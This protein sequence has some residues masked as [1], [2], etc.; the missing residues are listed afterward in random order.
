MPI[1]EQMINHL[2]FDRAQELHDKPRTIVPFTNIPESDALLNNI[3]TY[4]HFFILGCIMDRQI[5][6]E[7]AWNIPYIISK[8]CGGE[9]FENFLSLNS[10]VLNSIFFKKRLH[11]FN[12]QMASYFHKAVQIIHTE[13][14]DNAANIWLVGQPSCKEVIKRFDKFPGIGQKISTMATNILVRDFKVPIRD[15]HEID[16]SVDAQIKKVFKR[17]GIVPANASNQIIIEVARKIYPKYPGIADSVIWEIGRDWC[18]IDLSE[19]HKCF[20]NDY[21]PKNPVSIDQ[22]KNPGNI[23]SRKTNTNEVVNNKSGTLVIKSEKYRSRF[24]EL[25]R[26]YQKNIPQNFKINFTSSKTNAVIKAHD[27]PDGVHYEFDDWKDKSISIEIQLNRSLAPQILPALIEFSKR[28]ILDL[29]S[30]KIKE[31]GTWIRLQFF[32]DE[33]VQ[34][35]VISE[36]MNRLIRQ[37]YSEIKTV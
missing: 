25:L 2:L 34:I 24:E 7:R 8:E 15:V 32:F 5:P 20:L 12:K 33:D 37:T 10:D 3:E 13:Y 16:I 14:R 26:L 30:P 11:W 21:C 31:Y 6:A 22:I 19:C 36:S 18:K 29:P 23:R 4:P 28:Q 35:P 17:M 1:P 9:R 27:L